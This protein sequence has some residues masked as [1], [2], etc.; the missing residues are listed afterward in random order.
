MEAA[1]TTIESVLTFL[2]RQGIIEYTPTKTEE[3]V[4]VEENDI[5]NIKTPKAGLF[6][7][8]V[9]VGERVKKGQPMANIIDPYE[10]EI[11]KTIAADRDGRVF[12]IQDAPFILE[13]TLAFKMI[14]E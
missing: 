10:G 1:K 6:E 13:K 14:A 2:G 4:I 3:S 8:L 5:F 12:F 7:S 9:T 11:V